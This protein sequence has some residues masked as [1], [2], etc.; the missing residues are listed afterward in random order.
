MHGTSIT[1]ALYR[2]RKNELIRLCGCAGWSPMGGHRG[3]GG[4]GGP[5]PPLLENHKNIGFLSNTGP[6]PLKNHKATKPAFNFGPLS[7]RQRN[8]VSLAGRWWPA[9]SGICLDFPSTLKKIV[10]VGP[11]LTKVLGS[12]HVFAFVVR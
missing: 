5:D 2:Y 6:D 4:Q 12:A 10:K 9:Y 3:G 1:T 8:A 7:A 11:P